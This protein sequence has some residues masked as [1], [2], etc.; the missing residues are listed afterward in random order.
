MVGVRDGST[1]VATAFAP[2]HVTGVFAARLDARDPRARGSVGAG[3]VLEL[4][5]H[6][7]ARWRPGGTNRVTVRTVPSTPLPISLDAALRTKGERRGRLSISLTHELPVGQGFGMSAA[8]ALATAR[9]AA[10]AMGPGGRPSNEVAHLADLFGGGG[11]GGVAAIGGGG[12]E[13]RRRA[14]IP[15][16]GH[17]RRVRFPHRVFLATAGRAMPSPDLLGNPRFLAR[18]DA[19]AADGLANLRTNP[20][21]ASFLAAAEA[22]TD[23][24]GLGPASLTR[25][26]TALRRTGASVAQAMF[27]RAFFAVPSDRATR[28]RLV[29]ALTRERISA[30]EVAVLPPRPATL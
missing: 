16:W 30:V 18:V 14:G 4:G 22:F 3:L 11:L 17:V 24:V 8:G 20:D 9:A 23:R 12:L 21:P 13:I 10:A 28:E 7:V 5:V 15:P 6:A 1:S 29:R 26:I 25:Q 2:G 19:A 27:G